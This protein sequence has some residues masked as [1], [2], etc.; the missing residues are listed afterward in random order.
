MSKILCPI[1]GTAT[2]LSPVI[3]EDKRAYL[4]D[5]SSEERAV[6]G[7]ARVSAITDDTSPHYVSHGVFTCQACGERFVAK[8]HNWED[9]EWIPVYPFPH[10]SVAEEIPEPIKSEFE[11][12]NLCF[13]VGAY[14]ACL[15]MCRTVVIALQR[16]QNVSNLKELMGKG[17][18]S[19]TLYEKADEVRL[20]G[21]IVGHEDIMPDSV[22]REDSEQLLTYLESVLNA[23][24]VEPARFEALK[25]KRKQVEKRSTES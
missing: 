8:K 4:S 11:E 16:Q 21:N 14:I 18:I 24:Y 7:R 1:C 13:A 15:L 6:F 12:A 22:I 19:K 17:T 10:K 23:V 3:I 5:E 25:L 9:R 20:W 2:S